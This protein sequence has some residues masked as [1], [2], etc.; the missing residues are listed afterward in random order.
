MKPLGVLL[1]SN[2]R[3]LKPI[4]S[5]EKE[6]GVYRLIENRPDDVLKCGY[7]DAYN[8][9]FLTEIRNDPILDGAYRQILYADPWH[10]RLL[11]PTRSGECIGVD[12]CSW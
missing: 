10:H 8:P 1:E 5:D 7:L 12:L 9:E 11:F 3:I 6:M 4:C 2:V